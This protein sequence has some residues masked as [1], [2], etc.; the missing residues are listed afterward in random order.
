MSLLAGNQ[1]LEYLYY[2]GGGSFAPTE[3]KDVE[4]LARYADPPTPDAAAAVVQI[5]KGKGKALLSAVH[6]EYPLED[7]PARD[8]IAKLASKPSNEAVEKAEKARTTWV[9]KLLSGLGLRLPSEAKEAEDDHV[10]LHPTHPSPIFVLSHPKLPDLAANILSAPRIQAKLTPGTEGHQILRDGNDEID[11]SS[12]D[13]FGDVPTTLSERR[14]TKPEF[15]PAIAELSL[16]DK[17]APPQPP[18]LHALTKSLILPGSTPYSASWTPLFNF[19][20]YWAELDAERRR[21]GRRT[22]V[23]RGDEMS[24]GRRGERPSCGDL[25]F[26]GETVTST[27]T[28]LDRNPILL[29]N[30]PN[31]LAFLASFQLSGRGRGSNLW[32]SPAGCLQFS[33]L[34]TLPSNMANKLIFIQ[35]LMA[36]AVAE[37]VD[38]DGRLGVRIK[39]P[40]DIY[41]E[42][43]GVGG[44]DVGS[45][46]KG[47]AKLAGILVNTNFMNNQWRIVVGCGINVLNPL[48]TSS[49]SQLHGL[50]TE[51]V[52][53]SGSKD[54]VPPPPTM[55]GTFARIMHAFEV[56]WEQFLDN[57]GFEPFMQEYH[58][59]WLHS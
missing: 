26:Y 52:A 13:T 43:E 56:K 30:L 41:A 50:L 45:G 37:A 48:P 49:L 23:M 10:L 47:R 55:E 24:P 57:K 32:L 20:T 53:R 54:T 1:E 44:T 35:Y 29:N 34:L 38:E 16:D 46:F 6:F 7:P 39:W 19:D 59:R 17:P 42:T 8:A 27:Q 40:N 4:V 51:R 2:N 36:V 31:P 11:V 9:G 28:M 33:I 22:G 21:H 15:P 58:A 5:N 25:L 12:V 14:R 3:D 18:N